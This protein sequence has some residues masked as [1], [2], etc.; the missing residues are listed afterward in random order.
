MR[1]F[2]FIP[3]IET[4]AAIQAIISTNMTGN[5]AASEI[6]HFCKR[7]IASIKTLRYLDRPIFDMERET[8][9]AWASGGRTAEL[10]TKKRL[11]N[12]K[13]EEERIAKQHFRLWQEQVCA[14]AKKTKKQCFS[15][16]QQLNN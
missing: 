4:I 10:A 5:P 1:L 8:T 9:E 3:R 16:V 2:G 6:T 14:E 15:V 7:L 13:R 11:L 12:K